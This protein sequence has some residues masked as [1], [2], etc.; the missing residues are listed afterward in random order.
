M[1]TQIFSRRN[2]PISL[3]GFLV[4]VTTLIG[5]RI[6]VNRGIELD[7]VF[8]TQDD[9]YMI[10]LTKSNRIRR[11]SEHEIKGWSVIAGF[12]QGGNRELTI[13]YW[14]F[15]SSATAKK[16]AETHWTWTFA[17]P[18][19]FHPEFNPEDIIGDATW[20][21]IHRS[22]ENWERGPTDIY[23]VKYNLFVW[24]RTYGHSSHRLQDARDIARHIETKIAAVLKK[25]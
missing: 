7:P 21:R 1:K 12:Q 4:L 5:C 25:R 23:F 22:R 8:L 20:R 13:E 10:G 16:A 3:I 6:F 2:A 9:L 14:L 15:G 19:N 18:A 24:V 17:A 11:H